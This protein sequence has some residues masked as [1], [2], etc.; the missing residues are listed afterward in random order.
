MQARIEQSRNL[1][2]R[3]TVILTLWHGLDG[4]GDQKNDD[5]EDGNNDD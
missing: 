4:T 2:K 1:P 3:S 5:K